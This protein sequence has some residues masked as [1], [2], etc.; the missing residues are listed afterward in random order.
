MGGQPKNTGSS[1]GYNKT[2]CVDVSDPKFLFDKLSDPSDLS[3]PVFE[4]TEGDVVVIQSWHLNAPDCIQVEQLLYNPDTCSDEYAPFSPNCG[5]VQISKSCPMSLIAIP[6]RYRLVFC[7]GSPGNSIVTQCVYDANSAI[8][9]YINTTTGGNNMS[10]GSEPTTFNEVYNSSNTYP[11]P[12]DTGN[13][14]IAIFD[15]GNGGCTLGVWTGT[16]YKLISAGSDVSSLASSLAMDAVFI[17]N[18]VN[19]LTTTPDG[20]DVNTDTPMETLCAALL[21]LPNFISKFATALSGSPAADI[22]SINNVLMNNL[23]DGTAGTPSA[24]LCAALIANPDFATKVYSAISGLIVVNT[25]APITGTGTASNPIGLDISALANQVPVSA[26]APYLTGTGTSANPLAIDIAALSS[27]IS[28]GIATHVAAS[29]NPDPKGVVGATASGTDAQTFDLTFSPVANANC[30][31]G[32]ATAL[33]ILSMALSTA[34]TADVHVNGGSYAS[35]V[36]TLTYNNGQ[37]PINISI[38]S[39]GDAASVTSVPGTNTIA[40]TGNV[41]GDLDALD[42]AISALSGGNHGFATITS[43]NGSIV[44]SQ[45]G[46]AT[47]QAFDL[48]I[49]AGNIPL[50]DAGNNFT[51]DNVESALAELYTLVDGNSGNTS[52]VTPQDANGAFTHADGSGAPAT[53]INIK[54][55]EANNCITTGANGGNVLD[56]AGMVSSDNANPAANYIG[57]DGKLLLDAVIS[58][59]ELGV[60]PS[61]A[62]SPAIYWDTSVSPKRIKIYCPSSGTYV[63]MDEYTYGRG[64]CGSILPA[65]S[66]GSVGDAFMVYDGLNPPTLYVHDGSAWVAVNAGNITPGDSF[67]C[68][69]KGRPFTWNFNTNT[70]TFFWDCGIPSGLNLSQKSQLDWSSAALAS[71]EAKIDV[72]GTSTIQPWAAWA[73]TGAGVGNDANLINGVIDT[74]ANSATG[75]DNAAQLRFGVDLGSNYPVSQVTIHPPSDGP[76]GTGGNTFAF[77]NANL[78]LHTSVD[79]VTWVNSGS[80]VTATDLNTAATLTTPTPITARYLAVRINATAG[81]DLFHIGEMDV[82]QQID[83]ITP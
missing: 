39:T 30:L 49:L 43:S 29:I 13:S 44:V 18:L 71:A 57:S 80:S 3:S 15:D 35:G 34:P 16:T 60:A 79:G 45:P 68:T 53:T 61:P 76:Y 59:P 32:D 72:E 65:N 14:S 69:T 31:V 40:N 5:G 23:G 6:G 19:Y 63:C 62:G 56:P 27:V 1:L 12:A 48:T 38:P 74:T 67:Y 81:N 42:A 20:P 37:T 64:E 66:A 83:Y 10:C 36:L 17:E 82:C 73:N 9:A 78:E 70:G 46:T 55:A 54:G 22:V 77:F 75:R 8:A 50:V 4:V 25:Q 33:S 7:K 28:G 51:T 26:T 11:N 41:Q 24:I 52:V 47:D 58:I 21:A 2:G